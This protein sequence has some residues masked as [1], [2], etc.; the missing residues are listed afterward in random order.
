MKIVKHYHYMS[1]ATKSRHKVTLVV[2]S[3]T[4]LKLSEK[5]GLVS[6]FWS[7]KLKREA[8]SIQLIVLYA[9][10][11]EGKLLIPLDMRIR[12]PDPEGP[13]R[14]CKEQPQLVIEMIR[15]LKIRCSTKGLA[16]KGWFIVMDSWY[17]SHDLQDK[18]S[19]CGFFGIIEGKSN[20]VFFM[21]DERYTK[22]EL[23]EKIGWR[24]SKQRDIR[25]ARA[26]VA[27]PTF[28]DITIVLFEDERCLRS[29][30]MKPNL[31]SSVRIIGAY[32]LRW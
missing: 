24:D 8:S 28:G 2:D 16:T 30:I 15:G 23:S 26:N 32:K 29:L 3:T 5:L 6:T 21:G 18:I 27:S 10:I 7:G 13:G 1:D 25:Y 14:K 31:I 20:Y 9:V 11:G 4:L 12:R 17:S 19:Q 22:S